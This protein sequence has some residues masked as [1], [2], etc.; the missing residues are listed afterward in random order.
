M[1]TLVDGARRWQADIVCCRAERVESVGRRW[2]MEGLDHEQVTESSGFADLVLLG[3]VRGYLWNKLFRREV[4]EMDERDRLTSKDDFLVVLDALENAHRV[5]LLPQVRYTYVERA[6][7]ISSGAA[8]RLENVRFCCDRVVERWI[9]RLPAPR[10]AAAEAYF[11]L[12]FYL[13]PACTTPVHQRWGR[14]E[15]ADIRRQLAPQL[16]WRG[17]AQAAR[18]NRRLAVQAVVIKW[19][20]PLFPLLYRCGRA[21]IVVRAVVRAKLGALLHRP[22]GRPFGSSR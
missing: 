22:A 8:L 20:G 17:I 21:G 12:W 1:H 3:T 19:G 9:P 16:R 14:S 10:R 13:V 5:A 6:G 18:R 7:S 4:L 2:I 15:A 11:R